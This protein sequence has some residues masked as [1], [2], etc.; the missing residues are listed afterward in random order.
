MSHRRTLSRR[1][2]LR[3]TA[4]TATG[5]ATAAAQPAAPALEIREVSK[6]VPVVQEK[7][8]EVAKE[9]EKAVVQTVEKPARIPKSVKLEVWTGWGPINTTN[10]GV[11]L[12]S[13]KQA[14][15]NFSYELTMA[16]DE[17]KFLSAAAPGGPPD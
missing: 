6:E 16:A 13:F 11:I 7:L 8:K 1:D 3:V 10:T 15:P 12:D 4:V 14:N 5:A 2:F 9:V 17:N